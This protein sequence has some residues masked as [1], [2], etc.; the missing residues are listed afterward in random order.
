MTT[1]VIVC[2]DLPKVVHDVP[3]AVVVDGLCRDPHQMAALA[4]DADRVVLVLHEESFDLAG[5]QKALRSID[6]DPLGAQITEFRPGTVS[7]SMTATICG[8][9]A[10]ASAFSQSAP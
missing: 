1:T 5:I 2:G 8:L 6:V 4:L 7:A 3:D 9:R 10:R